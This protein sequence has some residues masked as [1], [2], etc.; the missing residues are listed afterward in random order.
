MALIDEPLLQR[1]AQELRMIDDHPRS[2][3]L[4]MIGKYPKHQKIRIGYFSADFRNHPV[5]Y[6]TAE[7]Y[8]VHDRDLFEIYAF[9]FGKAT[10]DEINLRIKAGV[11]HYYDVDLMS[12]KDTALLARSLEI[13]IAVDLG[14]LTA[15]SR[16]DIFAMSAAPI[17][18]SYIGYL[19]TMGTDYYDYL[20]ADPI[21]IPKENQKYYAEK[22]V[23]LPSFQVNDSTELPPEFTLSRKDVG[24]PDKGFVFCCFN[25]TY[26]FTPKTFDSWARILKAVKD[27]VFIIYTNNELSKTNLA[28][29]IHKRG[30]E[31]DRLIFADS[32]S[33]PQYLARYRVADLFLD[34]QPYNA[35]TTASDALKMGLPMITLIGKAYQAR[36]GASIV[37]ALNLPELITHTPE[38]YESLAIELAT[39]PDKL[40]TIK[41]KLAKNISTAP[42]YDTK[43]FT[44]NLES[45]YT[46]M[47]ERYHQGLKPDHI[48]VE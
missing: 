7:L 42:L 35:G 47:Y 37:N 34:T 22:I 18:L 9:S 25:N 20:I 14:G 30:I 8:E 10:N 24:L 43:L 38:E 45:A 23:Y 28:K 26:K 39:N 3:L 48:Y 31:L 17:Q 36:M 13:D 41:D 4:P 5:G 1:K 29:E 11:D 15:E 33:R 12:H 2:N 19:G 27:S 6:L 16:T 46:Q 40:K 32:I 44:K 21:M